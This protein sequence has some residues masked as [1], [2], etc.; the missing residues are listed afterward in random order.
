MGK[1][2]RGLPTFRAVTKARAAVIRLRRKRRPLLVTATVANDTTCLTKRRPGVGAAADGL[3]GP[4]C[5]GSAGDSFEDLERHH[6]HILSTRVIML[7]VTA[8]G[9]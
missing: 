9:M 6:P 1:V 5:V 3:M 4:L 8:A 2:G 7:S